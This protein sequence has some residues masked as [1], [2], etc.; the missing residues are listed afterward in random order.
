MIRMI[1]MVVLAGVLF[2]FS[3]CVKDWLELE[4]KSEVSADVLFETPEGFSIALNGIYT[5]LS[6][7]P[8]YGAELKFA[9]V[10]VLARCY[11]L[12]NT[13]YDPLKNYDYVTG[14]MGDKINA[15]WAVSYSTIANCN[16]LLQ[17]LEKKGPGFFKEHERKMLEGEV[18]AIRAMLY[19]DL[20][21]LFAPAPVVRDAVALPYYTKL[22]N[23][24]MPEKK[25]SEI[26]QLLIT[27]LTRSKELQKAYDAGVEATSTYQR[28]R[29]N[30]E[31]GFYGIGKRG[32]RMG[33]FA[34][35]ALLSK[36][37]LYAGNNQM[38]Y[39]NAMEL[40]DSK[41]NNGEPVINFTAATI[42]NAGAYDRLLSDDLIFALYRKDYEK[43]FNRYTF[44][45]PNTTRIFGADLNSDHR[46]KC[47]ITTDGLQLLKFELTTDKD[48][49][50]DIT[51]AIPMFRLSEQYHIAAETL[52][53]TDPDGALELLNTLRVKRGCFIPLSG[54]TTK[55]AF[56]DAIVND[57]RREFVG[58]GQLFFLYKRLNKTILDENGGNQTLTDKFVL[59]V[60][61]R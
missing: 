59:P 52:Y 5:N 57:A 36:V 29:F 33:Y 54:I 4:P 16:A 27:D 25:T 38:A 13:L 56:L 14:G 58:E 53:D 15:M 10:D 61:E 23:T 22:T 51:S 31:Q 9:F 50:G 20:L 11:D 44:Q 45:L 40:I 30:F 2:T 43:E 42:I 55:A 48:R 3:G 60:T 39:N 35:T 19:F 18:L 34:A 49:E 17:E 26:L 8:L 28:D 7:A 46:K 1:R 24:P 32:F 41:G 6:S 37:A 12:K 21:R 47:Y